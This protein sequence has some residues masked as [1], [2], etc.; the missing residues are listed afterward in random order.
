MAEL[1][2]RHANI[3]QPTLDNEY[4]T[5]KRWTSE[6]TPELLQAPAAR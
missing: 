5:I 6:M 1:S 4:G 2:P 3:I